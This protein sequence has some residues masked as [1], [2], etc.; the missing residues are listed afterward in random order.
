M[1]KLLIL[2]TCLLPFFTQAQESDRTSI[3]LGIKVGANF[4]NINGTYWQYGYKANFLGGVFAALNGPKVGLQ[5]E[6]LFSQST[7]VTGKGFND[8]YEDF[9]QTGKDSI[10]AGT[11]RV[12]NF[13]IPLLLNI[14][15]M[16]RVWVQLGPQYSGVISVN[17]VNNMMKDASQLFKNGALSAVGGLT[18]KFP[19]HLSITGRY[20]MGLS[21]VNNNTNYTNA[22]AN[23]KDDWK[24]RTIQFTL[25]YT[26]F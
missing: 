6:G 1:K 16:S 14:K 5:V 24:L 17:D 2:F 12:N 13:S 9:Y 25:N 18:I 3:D 20:I 22:S 4:T 10:Q 23:V 15:L 11:F 8:L 26:I 7:Y 21:N 19:I